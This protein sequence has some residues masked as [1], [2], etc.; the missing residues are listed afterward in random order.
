MFC[1]TVIPTI[2]RP[3][4]SRAVRSLLDQDFLAHEFEVIV[5]ND[6]GQQLPDMDWQTSARVR[7][8][9]TSRRERS[10]ARNAGAAVARGKY[11]H[12]LDDD[13]WML[14]GALEHFWELSQ[15]SRAAW[16]YGGYRLVDSN[17]KVLRDCYPDESGNCFVR[18][19]AGEWL[20]LQASLIESHVFFALGGFAPLTSLL[21]GDE[22]VDLTRQFSLHHDIS[23]SPSLVTVI[24]VG[25]E[26]STT[27]YINLQQQSRQS[28]ER[29]LGASGAFARLRASALERKVDSGYWQG[30]IVW[31]YLGSVL[32]NLQRKRPLAAASRLVFGITSLLLAGRHVLSERFWRGAIKPHITR[33]WLSIHV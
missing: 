1:S 6:S 21:G 24:R 28:R 32:W 26:S 4:L 30:R 29:A 16:L 23:G 14:P 10:T 7:V 27:N 22:D 33:G 15:T 18:F 19:T 2:N 17:Q 9:H 13:D 25:L 5:V 31:F 20:P 11:L 8:I 12:F 3:S